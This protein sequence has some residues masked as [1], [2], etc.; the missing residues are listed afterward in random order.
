VYASLQGHYD[1]PKANGYYAHSAEDAAREL[2]EPILG[3]PETAA[4]SK[5][6][7][8]QVVRRPASSD[9]HSNASSDLEVAVVARKDRSGHTIKKRRVE[10]DAVD[11]ADELER[12]VTGDV[13]ISSSK[14]I[15]SAKAKSRAK[16]G[17]LREGGPDSI[18][19]ATPKEGC[20]GR[21]YP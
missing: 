5:G 10:K 1:Y 11:M 8:K 21:Y 17:L 19:T 9:I 4:L 12:S 3:A 6:K 15:L 20:F 2:E 7:D 16:L 18:S 13:S 14:P